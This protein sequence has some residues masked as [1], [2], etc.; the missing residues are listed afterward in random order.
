MTALP[1]GVPQNQN[2]DPVTKFRRAYAEL[3]VR[4]EINKLLADT[5]GWRQLY[6]DH[7]KSVADQRR[8]L[9]KRLHVLAD[10]M[11][12]G[13]LTE[14]EEKFIGDIKKEAIELREAEDHWNRQTVDPVREPGDAAEHMLQ[15]AVAEAKRIEDREP[16]TSVGLLDVMRD[17]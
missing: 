7:A 14:D 3:F 10:C 6:G 12:R 4:V 1:S 5:D 17:A 11:E 15:D 8:D 16:L 9:S 2:V 13:R